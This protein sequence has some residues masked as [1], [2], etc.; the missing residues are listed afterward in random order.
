MS[1][2]GKIIVI[3][4]GA[5]AF[6]LVALIAVIF[7][8]SWLIGDGGL[9][10]SRIQGTDFGKTTDYAGCQAQGISRIRNLSVFEITESVKAQYFVKGC[11]ETSR[12]SADFC[13]DV[14]T[15]MQDIW[16]RDGWKDEQCEKLG[17]TEMSPNCRAVMR[18]RLEFCEKR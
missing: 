5:A 16:A 10:E 2:T 7:L 4:G 17:W 18:A 15:E 8:A 3:I 6:L 12:P 11:L 1:K 13:R 14:P 9:E